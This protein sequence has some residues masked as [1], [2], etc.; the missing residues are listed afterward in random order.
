MKGN[1]YSSVALERSPAAEPPRGAG[2]A[3]RSPGRRRTIDRLAWG[4]VALLLLAQWGL[5][6][7]FALREVVWAYPISFDQLAYLEQSYLTY[8]RMAEHGVVTGLAE[9]AGLIG[10]LP[11]IAAGATLHLQAAILYLIA[12]PSRLTALSL[13]FIYFAL[14]QVVLVA[15]LKWLTGRWSAAFLGLGLALTTITAFN[16]AGGLFDF[17]FDFI[18]FCLFGIF[19]CAVI[20]SRMFADWRWSAL[21][22]LAAAVLGTFRFITLPYLLGIFGTFLGYLVLLWFLRWRRLADQQAAQRQ[23]RGLFL[24]G[25]IIAVLASPVLWHHRHAIGDYYVM[26]HV[27]KGEKELRAKETGTT[28]FLASVRYYPEHLK[29]EHVGPA[30]VTL[31][32]LILLMAA[33]TAGIRMAMRTSRGVAVAEASPP[34]IDSGGALIFVALCLVVPLAV[35]TADTAKAPQVA[36]IMVMPLVWLVLLIVLWALRAARTAELPAVS[37][38]ALVAMA[39]VAMAVGIWTQFTQYNRRTYISQRRA[40]VNQL[41]AMYDVIGAQCQAMG[42]TS[43]NI[44]VDCI[45]DFL[46]PKNLTILNYERHGEMVSGEA[47]LGGLTAYEPADLFNRLKL[48]DFAIVTKR[49]GPQPAYQFPFDEQMQALHPQILAFCRRNMI[50]LGQFRVF[51]RDID[52]FIRP[53]VTVQAAADGWITSDGMT[54]SGLAAVLRQWPIIEMRGQANF[55]YLGRVPRVRAALLTPDGGRKDVPAAMTASGSDY[56]IVLRPEPADIPQGGRVQIH[57]DFDARFVPHQMSSAN[58]DTRELVM[59]LPTQAVVKRQER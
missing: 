20:R 11:L 17:R 56:T 25:I 28:T 34:Q 59:P 2:P 27:Q 40:E 12:G 13:N 32:E 41:T 54:V 29:L 7:Q 58:A 33:V 15:T 36:G 31:A 38:F 23:V 52:L 5:F 51:D 6:R 37:R 8:E 10:S 21:A 1:A 39:A 47:T 22:G 30:F 24:A 53:A 14:L 48:S 4:A 9:G 46:T 44:A 42:W 49:V 19:I 55:Q 3:S 45:E 43:P 50:E 26:G 57:V 18:A 16:Y 35:L